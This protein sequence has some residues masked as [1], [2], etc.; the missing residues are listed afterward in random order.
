MGRITSSQRKIAGISV[1]TASVFGAGLLF[2]ASDTTTL[3]HP[4]TSTPATAG[5][6]ARSDAP[7]VLGDLSNALAATAAH[8]KASVVYITTEQGARTSGRQTPRLE[9]PPEFRRF[10][11]MPGMPP[12]NGP[13]GMEPSP[14][15]A[16]A[17]GSGFIVTGDG[18]ILTNAHVVDGAERVTV[19]LLDHREFP[20]KVVGTDP[21]T[22]VA[23]LKVDAK[24]LTPAPLGSSDATQV[25]EM[26]L[27]VG[28]PLGERL[29]F[30]VTSG[31]VSA[32]GRSLDLPNSSARSIQNFIQTDAAINPGNSGGPLVN[33]R[34]EV[35]GMNAAIASPTGTYAGYGFAVPIDLAR[36][37]MDQLIKHGS[38][39]RAALGISVRDA[40][41]NDAAY[42]GLSEIRG[43][44]VQDFGDASSPAKSAG[45][46]P[47]DVIVAVDGTPVDYVGQLQQRVAFRRPGETVSVEVAR[48]GGQRVTIKVPLQRVS[49]PAAEQRAAERRTES[50]TGERGERGVAL[51]RLGITAL[52]S[53]DAAAERLGLPENVRGA[54]VMEVTDDG[55]AAGRLATAGDGG[56]DVV[57]AVE[58]RAVSSAADLSSALEKH[59]AGEIVTLRVY[60]VPA[61]SYRV[62]RIRLG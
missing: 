31:I 48:K 24:G 29:T 45:I 30:T 43:V 15:G 53:T 50:G 28:N 11:D 41:A 17:S 61:K 44:V 47:G 58:G 56:P 12:M 36:Q 6:V 46:L 62:E 13:E 20:A 19:R 18:Y 38:V 59:S 4:R 42:A 60:N 16:R 49:D 32:K 55:P 5:A 14:R 37:V 25:G 1:A 57:I 7:S 33:I 40:G 2:G 22:D 35:I 34:G 3:T 51:S 10:F 54:V 52:S 21:A 9:L 26:V 23:V 8:V 39:E 27:A